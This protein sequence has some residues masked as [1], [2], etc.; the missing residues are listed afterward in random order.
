M[1]EEGQEIRSLEVRGKL[2]ALKNHP[3]HSD[4]FSTMNS[5]GAHFLLKLSCETFYF[6]KSCPIFDELTFIAFTK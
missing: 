6:F 3:N 4:T 5:L 2:I 1:Q